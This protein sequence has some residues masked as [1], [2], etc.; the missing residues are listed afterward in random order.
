MEQATVSL[1]PAKAVW[2][3]IGLSRATFYRWMSDGRFDVAPVRLS[4]RAVR[5]RSDEVDEWIER[6]SA[7]R[8][9]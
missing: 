6:V 1:L 5:F 7:G 2:A 4:T 3:R 8:A 9:A